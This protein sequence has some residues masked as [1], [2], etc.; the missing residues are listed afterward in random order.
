MK[1]H[2]SQNQQEPNSGNGSHVLSKKNKYNTPDKVR[3]S[4]E[5]KY[6]PPVNREV[7]DVFASS[8]AV[9]ECKY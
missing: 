7:V 8:T 4:D 1:T 9:N 5:P 6:S 3:P 2:T